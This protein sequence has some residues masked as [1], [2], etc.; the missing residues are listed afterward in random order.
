MRWGFWWGCALF[1][2]ACGG[3]V[4]QAG[5]LHGAA[6]SAGSAGAALGS[7]GTTSS[8][9]FG[10]G[11]SFGGG[12]S[13]FG[14]SGAFGG[15][16]NAGRS[17]SDAAN[18]GVSTA[19]TNIG[20]AGTALTMAGQGG[21][22]GCTPGAVRCDQV[23]EHC[24]DSGVWQKESFV[25]ATDIVGSESGTLCIVKSDGTFGCIES[26]SASLLSPLTLSEPA[27]DWRHLFL[28]DDSFRFDGDAL[29]GIDSTTFGYCW[30]GVGAAIMAGSGLTQIAAGQP[31]LCVVTADGIAFCATDG[32]SRPSQIGP[33]KQIIIKGDKLFRLTPDGAVVSPVDAPSLP[34]GVY[35][36]IAASS[37]ELC[38]IGEAQGLACAPVAAP[39]DWADQHFIDVATSFSSQFDDQLI[40][41]VREDHV[42]LCNHIQ[43]GE[44][45]FGPTGPLT[46]I[47]TLGETMCGIGTDGRIGCFGNSFALPPDW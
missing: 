5:S 26:G 43:G 40:C 25:C 27:T 15:A 2:V 10:G 37:T 12:V 1:G 32:L 19:G 9:A 36:Y 7:A 4:E 35:S 24:D 21:A 44:V 45:P 20:S 31:G 17:G 6:A 23:R 22:L 16:M 8:S 41:G 42:V 29:C 13:A 47:T 38:G 34:D 3:R 14:G 18:G 30:G 39:A 46:R 11:S 28:P 33:A